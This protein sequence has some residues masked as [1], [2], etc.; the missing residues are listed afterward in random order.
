M[1]LGQMY[2]P[3]ASPWEEKPVRGN[4]GWLSH[5]TAALRLRFQKRV[6]KVQALFRI[7]VSCLHR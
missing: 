7:A 5:V 2:F 1:F 6:R 4:Y 3:I